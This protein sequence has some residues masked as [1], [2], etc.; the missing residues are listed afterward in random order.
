MRMCRGTTQEAS[1]KLNTP[2]T[3]MHN[4]PLAPKCTAENQPVWCRSDSKSAPFAILST[5]SV[6]TTGYPTS[7]PLSKSILKKEELKRTPIRN[8]VTERAI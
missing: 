8:G 1:L 6:H 7:L 3:K 4:Q 5:N 2:T